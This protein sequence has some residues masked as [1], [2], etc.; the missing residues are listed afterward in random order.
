VSLDRCEGCGLTVPG[1]TTGCQSIM[2]EQV[3]RHF[4]EVTY[5]GVHRLFVDTYCLQHPDRYC[6]SFKSLAAHLAHLC[7]SLEQGGTAAVPSEAIRLWVERHPHLEKPALPEDRGRLT[8]AH[9]AA[10]GDPAAHRRA[11][12]QWARSTWTAYAPLHAIARHWVTLALSGHSD[13]RVTR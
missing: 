8:V 6:V 7:W 5:F 11:V 1:G 10:A 2:D 9:V 13:R 12:D 3:A 4:S